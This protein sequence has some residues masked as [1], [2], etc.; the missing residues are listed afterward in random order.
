MPVV[1][2]NPS[3][4]GASARMS[5]HP[6]RDTKPELDLRRRLHALGLRYRV[7]VRPLPEVR[8]IAD[9]V[10]SRA[11]V[12]V[13]VDGCFWHG[14]ATHGVQPRSNRAWWTAKLDRTRTRD[15]DTTTRLEAEG[16]TVIRIWEHEDPGDAA[17]RIASAVAAATPPHRKQGLR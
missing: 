9:V 4:E 17:Q 11:R 5:R 6:R 15:A 7:H 3:S 16:W 8:R 1:P 2:V 10:F 14:C 12:A 13:F